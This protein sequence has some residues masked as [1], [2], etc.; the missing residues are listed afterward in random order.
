MTRVPPT[1]SLKPRH[2]DW[3]QVAETDRTEAAGAYAHKSWQLAPQDIGLVLLDVWNISHLNDVTA[4]ADAIIRTKIVPV[5]EAFAARGLTIIHAP[6][7][8]I[9]RPYLDPL[10]AGMADES[11]PAPWPPEDF[12]R[13]LGRHSQFQRYSEDKRRVLA[14]LILQRRIHPA[15]EPRPGE[16]IAA[17]GDDLH[18]IC[19]E[20]G[21]TVLICAGFSTNFC[22]ISRVYGIVQMKRWGFETILLRDCT[23]GVETAETAAT[24]TLAHAVITSLEM[25][26]HYTL[27]SAELMAALG[28]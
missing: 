9:A 18:R 21:V 2:Y 13:K 5:R 20:Q 24:S 22:M 12:R 3:V 28:G 11:A 17:T 23:T 26:Q 1:I 6:S 14:E 8:E 19:R 4:R 7:P 15:V 27:T 25:S 10:P 16:H